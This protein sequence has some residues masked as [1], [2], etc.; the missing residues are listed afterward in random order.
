MQTVSRLRNKGE[1]V[2]TK[3]KSAWSWFRSCRE[4]G[5]FRLDIYCVEYT[6][7]LLW[8]CLAFLIVYWAGVRTY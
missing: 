7:E 3:T 2:L 6:G 1:H 5:H 8:L 4:C